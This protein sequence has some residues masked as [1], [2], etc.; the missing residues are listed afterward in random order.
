MTVHSIK[1]PSHNTVIILD[2][3]RADQFRERGRASS[4]FYVIL[5][6]LEKP[7]VSLELLLTP[8]P[9][10]GAVVPLS[11]EIM[12]LETPAARTPALISYARPAA[13]VDTL[14]NPFKQLSEDYQSSVLSVTYN[15]IESPVRLQDVTMEG[16]LDDSLFSAANTATS[17]AATVTIRRPIASSG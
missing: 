6:V 14:N 11:M 3:H 15:S 13:S 2:N 10:R 8:T 5:S 12:N 4:P 9:R 1:A 17:P 16:M 7:V